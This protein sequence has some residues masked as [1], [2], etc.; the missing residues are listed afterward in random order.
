MGRLV[1]VL[2][3][4]LLTTSEKRTEKTAGH[5]LDDTL[6]TAEVKP[7]LVMD[8]TASMV[9]KITMETTRGTA[10]LNRTVKSTTAKQQAAEVAWQLNDVTAVIN[11][12]QVQAAR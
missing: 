4:M 7:K 1:L 12:L 8:Q 5:P 2:M 9:P 11:N 10:T 6:M 3:V